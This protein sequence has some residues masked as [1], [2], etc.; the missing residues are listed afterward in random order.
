MNGRSEIKSQKH[1][2]KPMDYAKLE[3]SVYSQV[4]NRLPV[5]I[6][7]GEGAYVWDSNGKKYLDFF[8]GIAVLSL[9]HC[10]PKVTKT[11]V[12][13]AGKL[14]HTSNWVYTKP[15]LELA[16]KLQELS[17]MGKVFFTNSGSESVE[18]AIKLSRKISG[19][20]EVIS[21]AQGFHGRSLGALSLTYTE[22]YRKPFM[23]GDKK[24]VEYNNVDA[25]QEAVTKETGAVIIEPIQGEAGVI[26]P[27]AGYLKAVRDLTADKGVLLIVDEVQTAFGRSGS[28]F[29]FQ[30]EKISPDIVCVAKGMGSGFPI[31]ATIFAQGL[32]FEKGE[33]GGTFPGSPLACAV[34][35]TVIDVIE[36]EYLIENSL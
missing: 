2:S 19:K 31:G 27:D 10:H 11:I 18:C 30:K 13:Q 35:K 36:E 14:V 12:G 6:E 26:I 9:G 33:H 17:G 21:F 4:F 23:L 5:C 25:I 20:K 3:E 29:A 32:D 28:M 24:F 8:A 22:K 7:R 1:N 16:E 34:A 15:Q